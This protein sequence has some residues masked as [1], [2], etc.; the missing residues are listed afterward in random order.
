MANGRCLKTSNTGAKYDSFAIRTVS[1]LPA[2]FGGTLLDV[3]QME[4]KE[5]AVGERLFI[6]G[7]DEWWISTP[8]ISIDFTDVSD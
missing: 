3:F 5:P 6:S 7:K 8:I 4:S 1:G 2:D